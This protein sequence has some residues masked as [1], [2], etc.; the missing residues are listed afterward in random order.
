MRIYVGYYLRQWSFYF[1]FHYNEL[2]KTCFNEK[3]RCYH[4]RDEL[5]SPNHDKLRNEII[6]NLKLVM[7]QPDL[8]SVSFWISLQQNSGT[9][10]NIWSKQKFNNSLAQFYYFQELC[11]HT[12]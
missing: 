12:C 2:I 11:K 4:G 5:N 8:T 6:L 1:I 10:S 7:T 3:R 9:K